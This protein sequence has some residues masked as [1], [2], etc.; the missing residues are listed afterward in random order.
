MSP[1][2]DA[3]PANVKRTPEVCVGSNLWSSN[4]DRRSLLEDPEGTPRRSH[5]NAGLDIFSACDLTKTSQAAEVKGMVSPF[6]QHDERVDAGT[7]SA[8][9]TCPT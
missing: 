7:T 2:V 1:D 3:R 8:E 6:N 4:D 5:V 9:R